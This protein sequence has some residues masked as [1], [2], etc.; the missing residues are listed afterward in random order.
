M[1][2]QEK[3]AIKQQAQTTNLSSIV[4]F[5][6]VGPKYWTLIKTLAENRKCATNTELSYLDQAVTFVQKNIIPNGN[7]IPVKIQNM[8]NACDEVKKK[9]L[10]LGVKV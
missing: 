8:M 5:M 3:S 4:D 9:L 6:K 2:E 7:R 10:D 1:K